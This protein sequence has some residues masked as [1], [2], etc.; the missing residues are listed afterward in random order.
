MSRRHFELIASTIRALD[1]P[2]NRR[3]HVARD[4]ADALAATNDRFDRDRFIKA[5]GV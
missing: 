5:C 3:E 2:A 4:F 1:M